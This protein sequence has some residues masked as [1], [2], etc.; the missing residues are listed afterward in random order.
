MLIRRRNNIYQK[1]YCF[2]EGKEG[3]PFCGALGA[4][5]GPRVNIKSVVLIVYSRILEFLGLR[6][7]GNEANGLFIQCFSPLFN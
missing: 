1:G 2:R 4:G 7:I 6:G 5:M 3:K